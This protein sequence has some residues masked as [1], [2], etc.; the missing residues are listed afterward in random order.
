MVR[1]SIGHGHASAPHISRQFGLS[2]LDR[3]YDNHWKK[4]HWNQRE[5][6]NTTIKKATMGK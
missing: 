1:E 6:L 5:Y 3:L 2:P 4:I